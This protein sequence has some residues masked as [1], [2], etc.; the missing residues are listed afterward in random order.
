MSSKEVKLLVPWEDRFYS[1]DWII[2]EICALCLN[3]TLQ[4]SWGSLGAGGSSFSVIGSGS[5]SQ[6]LGAISEPIPSSERL[7]PGRECVSTGQKAGSRSVETELYLSHLGERGFCLL[8]SQ[9][10]L[11]W[12]DWSFTLQALFLSFLF[13]AFG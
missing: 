7:P 8:L 1:L 13:S 4:S 12:V 5:W 10:L 9:M 2:L 3:K 11:H 6:W